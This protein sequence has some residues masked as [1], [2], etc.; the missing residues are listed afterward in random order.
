MAE[1][2]RTAIRK[3]GC[4][5][6][7]PASFAGRPNPSEECATHGPFAG[8]PE[9]G[10]EFSRPRLNRHWLDGRVRPEVPGFGS[11]ENQAFTEFESRL[12]ILTL[13]EAPAYYS[14]PARTSI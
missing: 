4:T 11:D 9:H 5:G 8:Q 14:V 7:T 1:A 2:I 3:K 12:S 13:R 6:R 10:A